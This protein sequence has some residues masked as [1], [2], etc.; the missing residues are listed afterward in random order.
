MPWRGT[1]A[2]WNFVPI[3]PSSEAPLDSERWRRVERILD[4][5]LTADPEDVPHR[6]D[7]LC[8][9]DLALREEVATLLAHAGTP[10]RFLDSPPVALAAAVVAERREEEA[11]VE[12][13]GRH[14]GAYRIVR[15]IGRGG[16]AR[17]FLAERVAG[18]F[19]QRVALK[20]LR[21]GLDAEIDR[22]RFRAE[23]QILA[24]LNHPNIARLFDGGVTA[25]GQHYLVLEHVDGEPID[26]YCESHALTTRE[27][28]AL[29]LRVIDAVKYAHRNLIVH[30]DLKPSNILIDREGRVKLLDFG[31]AKLLQPISELEAAPHTR[32]H[33]RWLTPEYAAPEQILGGPIST[34]TDVYQLGAVLYRLLAGTPPFARDASFHELEA[35]VIGR[36]PDPPSAAVHRTSL[37]KQRPLRG[38][39][40]AIVLKALRKE[41][42]ER[43][44]SAESMGDDIRRHLS[45]LPVLARRQ[46]VGYRTRRFIRRNRRETIGAT[47]L[48]LSLVVGA[49]VAVVEA[50]HAAVQRARAEAASRD[51][52]GV[53]AFVLGLFEA[54]APGEARG[55]TLTAGE[56]VRRGV[57]RAAQLRDNP[58]EQA[59]ML[60]V[61]SRLYFGL[62]RFTD[63]YDGL[64][65]ALSLRQA[66]RKPNQLALAGTFLQLSQTLIALARLP[67][68]DSAAHAALDLQRRVLGPGDPA[69]AATLHR[70]GDIAVYRG[71]LKLAE[72]YHRR[73]LALRIESLGPGDSLTAM[74]HLYVGG[75]LS[76]RG[77][78][79]DAEREFRRALAIDERVHG[80]YHAE[81]ADAVLQLAYLLEDLPARTAEA[82]Q[83]LRRGFEIRRRVF[84]DGH[85]MTTYALGDLASFAAQSGDFATAV[86][87]AQQYLQTLEAAHGSRH[88]VIA[89][90]RD[91]VAAI[92][93]KSGRLTEAESLY[94]SALAL[95]RSIRAGDH[96]N[97]AGHEVNL[98][99]LLIERRRYEEAESL[100]RDAV[101]IQ[102]RVAGRD[103]PNTSYA[104]GLLGMLLTRTG[105]YHEADSLL[106]LAV[107]DAE[108]KM[109]P[110]HPL[111]RELRGWRDALDSARAT[112]SESRRASA[113][114]R[115]TP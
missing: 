87:M 40:D 62:G 59:G 41:P 109:S 114:R 112:P 64:E 48:A 115:P 8:G 26:E 57:A 1:R 11:A 72:D 90:A 76:R 100:L 7:E 38:D 78:T 60:E 111:V 58:A 54:S 81:T 17:V 32:T 71:D 49:L 86:P 20:L 25:D 92:L 63:A 105:R 79:V 97:V 6:L 73:A 44:A 34:L 51:A 68:A 80:P 30:R 103:H 2:P 101:R 5:A 14:I 95:E 50:R 75:I 24:T 102:A 104:R 65:R 89:T 67:Q 9:G 45:G 47:L 98:A 85:P 36:E 16:M 113:D 18:D 66:A 13:T 93:F 28:L 29:F 108:A 56:L 10:H 94:R 37:A 22:D 21:P 69:L 96:A 88:P 70:L 12:W 74:S 4:A 15:E 3:A 107:R 35:A 83:L 106:R 52:A 91:Q 55:D 27:R 31:L 61:T 43:Y 39:I 23:R 77:Q 110:E 19:D 53:T 99:R 82:G 84:G 42:E 33:Q 46:T